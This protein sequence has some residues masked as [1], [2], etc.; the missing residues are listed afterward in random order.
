MRVKMEEMVRGR[1]WG[2][3]E[4]ISDACPSSMRTHAPVVYDPPPPSAVLVPGD[5]ADKYMRL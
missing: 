2:E 1:D 5:P 3:A 4:L